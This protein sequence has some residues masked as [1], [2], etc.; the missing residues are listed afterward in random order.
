MDAFARWAGQDRVRLRYVE[1]ADLGP[2]AGVATTEGVIQLNQV[3]DGADAIR[4]AMRHEL[5]HTLDFGE[6]L[7]TKAL[8]WLDEFAANLPAASIVPIEG[9]DPNLQ[10][11]A[12]AF[13]ELCESLTPLAAQVVEQPCAPEEELFGTAA[14]WMRQEVWREPPAPALE[15]GEEVVSFDLPFYDPKDPWNRF[16][17]SATLDPDALLIESWNDANPVG[18]VWVDRVTGVQVDSLAQAVELPKVD[19]VPGELA[20][21]GFLSLQGTDGFVVGTWYIRV[22]GSGQSAPRVIAFDGQTWRP[23]DDTCTKSI[24]GFDRSLFVSNQQLWL[25]WENE[26]QAKWGPLL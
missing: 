24:S 16:S 17:I 4:V 20:P 23:V 13:A 11:R 18:A 25:G 5:C 2:R 8:D 1:F 26:G 19:D 15:V 21:A 6:G 3:L 12:E 10:F 14:R 9:V 7:S 22:E